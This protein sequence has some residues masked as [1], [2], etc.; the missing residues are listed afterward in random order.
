M[1]DGVPDTTETVTS[2]GSELAELLVSL[3]EEERLDAV[4]LQPYRAAALEWNAL[5][6]RKKASHY[7]RLAVRFG[8][9]S[10]GSQNPMVRD[11]EDLIQDPE[12]H[13]SWKLRS[14]GQDARA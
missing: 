6:E 11:M 2:D 4:M 5:G 1:E 9:N 10:F 13:W 7:A 12:L 3:A 8:I 14:L